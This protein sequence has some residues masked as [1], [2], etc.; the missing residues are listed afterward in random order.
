MLLHVVPVAALLALSSPLATAQPVVVPSQSATAAPAVAAPAEP[1]FAAS[2][3]SPLAEAPPRPAGAAYSE[4]ELL[5][6]G[7]A[8][9]G[10][11]SGGL[12][13]LLQQA[14]TRFGRPN[15]YI[16]GEE[17]SGALVGGLRYGEGIL[18]TAN[19]GR[20]MIFWQGPSLGWDFGGSGSRVMMLVYNL[21]SPGDI[22][23]RFGGVEGSAY[24]VGGLS[25]TVL[26][27]NEMVV[28]PVRT[29]VGARLGV[30]VGYLKFT[31]QPTWN[32]F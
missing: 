31:P 28:V 18:N 17:A 15:G 10:Q 27:A 16:L 11:T 30:N 9:F 3:A 22:I 24:A 4:D 26:V 29:G 12:A 21:D 23:G 20:H 13:D 6:A 32:P 8:F 1:A 19:M 5:D 2:S 25:M 14:F 7:H